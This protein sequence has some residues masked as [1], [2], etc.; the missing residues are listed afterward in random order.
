VRLRG[1]A[2]DH[3]KTKRKEDEEK[4]AQVT[5]TLAVVDVAAVR[6]AGCSPRIIHAKPSSAEL[7]G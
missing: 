5:V 7:S 1:H 2:F 6:V 4:A 3:Y